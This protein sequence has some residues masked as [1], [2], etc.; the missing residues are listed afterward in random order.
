M[1][2]SALALLLYAIA[3]KK[4]LGW[5]KVLLDKVF[6]LK[7]IGTMIIYAVGGFWCSVIAVKYC[8]LVIA[9]SIMSLEPFFILLL[10]ILFYR[11]IP[12]KRELA[13]IILIV[14]GILLIC[15]G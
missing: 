6:T 10:M 12:K 9:S 8:E 7:L 14:S 2:F 13:S 4:I 11:Y 3:T 15:I 5:I 1:L